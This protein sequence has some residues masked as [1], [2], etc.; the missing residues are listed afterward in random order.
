MPIELYV[1]EINADRTFALTNDLELIRIN[2]L[3]IKSALDESS[4]NEAD[5]LFQAGRYLGVVMVD[6]N[7]LPGMMFFDLKQ[8]RNQAFEISRQLFPLDVANQFMHMFDQISKSYEAKYNEVE[9]L[10]SKAFDSPSEN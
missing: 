10:V 9:L 8:D 4:F 7:K 5:W 6:F 3:K 2:I 1:D